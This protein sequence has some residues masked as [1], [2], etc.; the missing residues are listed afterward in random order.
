MNES[1][2][3]MSAVVMLG[4]SV[5]V[6]FMLKSQAESDTGPVAQIPVTVNTLHITRVEDTTA[7]RF[8]HDVS[9]PNAPIVAR[10]RAV[11]SAPIHFGP[12]TAWQG[13]VVLPRRPPHSQASF[14]R[15][16]LKLSQ[17]SAMD[18]ITDIQFTAG[19]ADEDQEAAAAQDVACEPLM[20]VDLQAG[21][22]LRVLFSAPCNV[23]ER[24]EIA[25]GELYFTEIIDEEGGVLA[26]LPAM[27]SPAQVVLR[28]DEADDLSESIDVPDLGDYF[29]VGLITQAIMDFELHALAPGA[30][31][32]EAGH[33]HAGN[34]GLDPA[35]GRM[36]VL[37]NNDVAFPVQA[38]IFTAP[39]EAIAT[40][41]APELTVELVVGDANCG[42]DRIAMTVK[43]R[44]GEMMDDL[45]EV[46][47]PGCD[48]VGDLVLLSGM[49]SPM[50]MASADQ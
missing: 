49:Y 7:T 44:E 5:S 1:I 30:T 32:N 14:L 21:A 24:V 27:A 34:P 2:I 29:R 46:A 36:F 19:E 35:S 13:P 47:V 31:Y 41:G 20:R 38:Q 50:Q 42:L 17:S 33:I 43:T 28:M 12:A 11:H 18:G 40:E 10:D 9:V 8:N 6:G 22:I 15:P 25:H 3:R 4:V 26:F 37:G 39:I 16:F 23:G 48:A 45:I